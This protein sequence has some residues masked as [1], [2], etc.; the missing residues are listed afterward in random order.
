MITERNIDSAVM[1]TAPMIALIALSLLIGLFWSLLRNKSK[2]GIKM[3][4]PLIVKFIILAEYSMIEA[5]VLAMIPFE[6]VTFINFF[7]YLY[8]RRCPS[9]KLPT[10]TLTIP[11]AMA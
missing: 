10:R 7:F 3:Y 2:I 6:A 11:I 8:N 1:N 5:Q 9:K 4:V